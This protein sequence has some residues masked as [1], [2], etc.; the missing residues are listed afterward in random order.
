MGEKAQK[1]V[2][3]CG[4][5]ERK[6]KRNS[7][8]P[9]AFKHKNPNAHLPPAAT[10]NAPSVTPRRTK[11]VSTPRA[12]HRARHLHGGRSIRRATPPSNPRSSEQRP[13]TF[14]PPLHPSR[15]HP[16]C[17]TRA[18][19]PIAPILERTRSHRSH[20]PGVSSGTLHFEV[21]GSTRRPR[22]KW[23]KGGGDTIWPIF[24]ESTKSPQAVRV[25]TI[26]LAA[27]LQ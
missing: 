27:L 26:I 15:H 19:T 6:A 2:V 10:T 3:A 12:R 17:S 20:I 18:A 7:G 5:T 21:D 22:G 25:G 4:E 11:P 24:N 23:R 1:Q 8:S 9:W 13:I 14:A 16:S